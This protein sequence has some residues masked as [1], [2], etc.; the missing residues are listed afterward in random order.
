MSSRWKLAGL[1]GLAL[2]ASACAGPSKLSRGLDQGYNQLYVNSPLVSELCLP[3]ILVGGAGALVGDLLFVNPVYW[4][5]D[6][7]EGVGTPYYYR[8]P[9]VPVAEA[10]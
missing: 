1:I 10:E 7:I 2:T 4:W 6:A 3:F 5:K 8:P 9:V